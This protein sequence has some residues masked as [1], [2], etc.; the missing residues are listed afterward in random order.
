MCYI[1]Y[2]YGFSLS[3][4]YGKHCFI[5]FNGKKAR[6]LLVIT[7]NLI[8]VINNV[9]KFRMNRFKAREYNNIK[10]IMFYN[11]KKMLQYFGFLLY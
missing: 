8:F 5:L 6:N 4:L 7:F 2:F 3:E 9:K 1:L 10:T 11:F